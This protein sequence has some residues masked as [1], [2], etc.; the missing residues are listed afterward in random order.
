[1]LLGCDGGGFAGNLT[2]PIIVDG[3]PLYFRGHANV[4][5]MIT[6]LLENRNLGE[7]T[8]IMFTGDFDGGLGVF[9][10]ANEVMSM[11]PKT[12]RFKVIPMSGIILNHKNF[13]GKEVISEQMKNFYE[14]ANCS[15]SMEPQCLAAMPPGEGYKCMF[16]ENAMQYVQAPMFIIGSTYDRYATKCI[17][18]AEP[19]V[20]PESGG[21]GNCSAVPGWDRCEKY[22]DE[23]T[24]EQW[25]LF[26]NMVQHM[27]SFLRPTLLLN[28]MEMVCSNTLVTYLLLNLVSSGIFFILTIPQCVQQ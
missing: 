13:E 16:A 1:M 2:D 24:Y 11:M 19:I 4:I 28:L 5:A 6:D 7:A 8:D 26:K 27:K 22:N 18:G 12:A 23:C 10:H 17:I 20:S 3:T 25:D 14:M 21:E 9:L 15:G